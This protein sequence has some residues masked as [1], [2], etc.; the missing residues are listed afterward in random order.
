MLKTE[1]VTINLRV[2][3]QKNIFVDGSIASNALDTNGNLS[4]SS[5]TPELAQGGTGSNLDH[6]LL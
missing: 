3:L 1:L 2:F 4:G 6:T 5:R